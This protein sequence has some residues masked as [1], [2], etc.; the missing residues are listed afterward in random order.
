MLAADHI[1]SID[2]TK[3]SCCAPFKNLRIEAPPCQTTACE[4]QRSAKKAKFE[5][6]ES[7]TIRQA[8]A[9]TLSHWPHVSPTGEMMSSSGWFACNVSDRV[10]CIYCN[11]ICHGWTRYDD[12][13][14]V[15][16][17]LAPRCPFVLAMPRLPRAPT[18]IN[19]SLKEKFKPH[20]SS[21]TGPSQRQQT[22]TNPAWTH[23]SPTVDEL[24]QAGFFYSGVQSVVTCFYCNGSL[25]K[26]SENDN[27]MFE[28][29]RWFPGCLYAKHLCGDQLYD[30]IQLANKR[31]VAT[32]KLTDGEL[33]RIVSA[34]LDLPVVER[35]RSDYDLSIIKR[36][37][38][39][40]WRIK[41]DDYGSD[42]DLIV[43]CRILK[44]QIE[45]IRGCKDKI[46]IPSKSHC[47]GPQTEVA[48]QSAGECLICL[49]DEK[50]LACMPC[51]HLCACV[52]CG[53]A[54]RSCP[55][56][57]QKIESFMRINL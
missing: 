57:R 44:K 27:P 42:I 51:G 37:I 33:S 23:T 16:A 39:D 54:L 10:I 3:Q 28:H 49:A 6:S 29:A 46:V 48:K 31:L 50:Q 17:R 53:Y 20:H 12:P 7:D 30:K 19:S 56:C 45:V 1:Q 15:H 38:E 4:D 5:F 47:T 24:V 35:L 13:A 18:M 8:R 11:T 9:R 55:V 26:W 43:A 32:N 34:R 2:F 36:C 40:Q 41:N 22:F 25:H 52:P 21:M 14:E